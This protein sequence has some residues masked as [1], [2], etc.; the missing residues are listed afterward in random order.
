MRNFSLEEPEGNGYVALSVKVKD[1]FL[2]RYADVYR[3]T[4]VCETPYRSC[5]LRAN[6]LIYK[7]EKK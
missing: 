4:E 2:S 3:L 7:F 5:D 6:I 1:E